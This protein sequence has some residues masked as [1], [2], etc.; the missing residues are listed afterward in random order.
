MHKKFYSENLKKRIFFE[1]QT[2]IRDGKVKTCPKVHDE[3][4]GVI[5]K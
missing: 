3:K 4:T 2:I 5:L 1:I